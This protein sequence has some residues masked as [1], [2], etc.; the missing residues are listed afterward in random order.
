MVTAA[1]GQIDQSEQLVI[2]AV[3]FIAQDSEGNIGVVTSFGFIDKTVYINGENSIVVYNKANNFFTVEKIKN[4]SPNNNLVFLKVRGDLTEGGRRPPL[5]LANSHTQNE[6]LFYALQAK[7]ASSPSWFQVETVQGVFSLSNRLDFLVETSYTDIKTAHKPANIPVFNQKGEIVSFV[8]DGADH[9]L[10]GV[11]LE[12]MRT[13]LQSPENCSF[14]RGCVIEARKILYKKAFLRGDSQASYMVMLHTAKSV[15]TFKEFMHSIGRT[16]SVSINVDGDFFRKDSAKW[17]ARFYY[18]W[19]TNHEG[20][21]K[22]K[23]KEYFEFLERESSV[24]Q[25][26]E[27]G[28]P[29]FQ[30]LMGSIYLHLD[31]PSQA[32]YWFEKSARNGYIPG[33]WE[34]MRMHLDSGLSGLSA[35]SEKDHTMARQV[36]V[37][38]GQ[39]FTDAINFIKR[40]NEQ[41]RRLSVS[42]A[43]HSQNVSTAAVMETDT[44]EN[45]RF[46]ES[47]AHLERGLDL[48]QQL[49]ERNYNPAKKLQRYFK[50]YMQEEMETP[51]YVLFKKLS[52]ECKGHFVDRLMMPAG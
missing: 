44:D 1:S 9:T 34:E 37:F 41:R 23:R 17:D 45:S 12:E 14:V 20:L 22:K 24:K 2:E 46:F 42:R 38:L 13:F 4:I 33:L 26:A 3:G 32:K 52:E 11:P 31:D 7:A 35:L 5:S 27:M 47:L 43:E 50:R 40:Y 48:L 36:I 8:S 51:T 6:P 15:G 49:V 18:Y 16:Y 28:H 29:H 19:L 39:D 30:Y 10:Y 25:L 21:S